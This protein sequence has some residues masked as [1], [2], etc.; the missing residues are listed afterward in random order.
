[1]APLLNY[2]SNIFV[3]FKKYNFSAKTVS[4]KNLNYKP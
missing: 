2:E 4:P 3:R 1:M